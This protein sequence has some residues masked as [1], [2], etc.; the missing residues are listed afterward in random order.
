MSEPRF[1]VIVATLLRPSYPQFVASLRQQ[2]CHDYEFIART[3]PPNEYRSRNLG[4]RQAVGQYLVFRDDDTVLPQTHLAI[5]AKGIRSCDPAPAAI[6]G[7]LHG[8]MWGSGSVTL[9]EPKWGVGANMAIRRDAFEAVGGFEEDWGLGHPVKGW[10]ADTDI[11]WKLEDRY[12][13]QILWLND[14][15]VMHPGPMGSTFQPEVE[16]VFLRRWK[17]RAMER[18]LT[19]DPRL[20]QT[21]LQTQSLTPEEREKVIKARQEMRK[22]MPQIPVLPQEV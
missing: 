17:T 4:A 5:L 6:G 9:N 19:V 18:F 20:Q 13:G 22:S 16:D 1:S 3:D 7:P 10:R 11:W 15:V 14:L 12:P 2:T 8:N 21:L